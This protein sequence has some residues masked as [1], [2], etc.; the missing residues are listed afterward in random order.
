M[1]N[2]IFID[3]IFTM[4]M[5]TEFSESVRAIARENS[6]PIKIY[7]NSPGGDV[8]SLKAILGAMDL[9]KNEFITIAVGEASSA[10]A[11]LLAH[12]NKRFATENTTVMVHEVW[13]MIEGNPTE[14]NDELKFLEKINDDLLGVL[15]ID[16]GKEIKVLKKDFSK[17]NLY[18]DAK[19]AKEYGI[20]DDI[21]TDDI[22]ARYNL[23]RKNCGLVGFSEPLTQKTKNEGA[24]KM[25]LKKD[26]LIS[27]LKSRFEIDVTALKTDVS[28][29]TAEKTKIEAVNKELTANLESEKVAH[30]KL[31][32]DIELEAKER[33]FE[34]GMAD[35]KVAK[36]TKDKFLAAFK[37]AKELDEVINLL[38]QVIKTAAVGNSGDIADKGLTT[39]ELYLHNKDPKKYTVDFIKSTRGKI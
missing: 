22:V 19:E 29:S 25:E 7:I 23:Q 35:G 6:E 32:A 1:K 31:R 10:A 33:I 8:F 9:V 3:G 11:F 16:T 34:K 15:S 2:E 13:G 38:P 17:K 28:K 18:M 27:Q 21:V 20:I 39:S 4:H 30:A 5:A 14:L 24:K 36:A 37:T 26:E 12:G